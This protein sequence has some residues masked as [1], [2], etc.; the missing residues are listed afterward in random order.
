MTLAPNSVIGIVGGGQLGRMIGLAAAR[1]GYRVHVFTDQADSSAAQIVGEEP[2][3]VL[4]ASSTILADA[5]ELA[6]IPAA[7]SSDPADAAVAE[8]TPPDAP[9]TRTCS[10]FPTAARCS[11]FSAV[12]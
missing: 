1:L 2:F 10:P 6:A 3:A 5:P 8:P 9:A 12:P 4:L 7:P 11:M